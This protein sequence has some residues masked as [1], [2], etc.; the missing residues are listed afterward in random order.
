MKNQL[1]RRNFI[2]NSAITAGVFSIVPRHVLGRGFIAPSD[3]ITMGLIGCGRQRSVARSLV[4][5]TQE[6]EL[7]ACSDLFVAKME[8]FNQEVIKTYA[9]AR[10]NS[11]FK[12]LAMYKDYQELIARDD[13]DAVIVATPDHWHAKPTIEALNRGKDVYCE[14]PLSHTVVEGRAMV[15]ATRKNNRVLQ[16]G[17]MQRSS[18]NKFKHACEL[19]RNGYLGE[20]KKVE[21]SVGDPEIPYDLKGEP[22]PAGFNWEKWCGPSAVGPYSHFLAPP[23]NTGL[24]FWPKWRDYAEYGG[25]QICDWGAHMFDIAQWALGMD[26]TGPVEYI[27]PKD[28]KAV[29]L[30]KMVYA[31]GIEM[32]HKDFGRGNAVRFIGTEGTLDV[33]R[34]FVETDPANIVTAKIK[35]SETRLYDTND[36]HYQDF[37]TCVKSRK[38]PICDVEIGHRTASICNLANIAYHVNRPLRWDPVKEKFNNRKAN[39]LLKKKYR[40]GYKY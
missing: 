24:K 4:S 29:R 18:R 34:S 22:I 16:T 28:P 9:E 13:I 14:K 20:I 5:R 6:G 2:K 39:K 12:G 37:L 25:G 26:H 3:K 1:S 35:D 23:Q 10:N 38:Q 33:S 19:V 17:S 36:N 27:P 8:E 40:K 31:N 15:N 30:L 32:V 11:N 7:L 21:V